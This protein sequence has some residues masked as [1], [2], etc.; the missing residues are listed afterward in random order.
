MRTR[1]IPGER[2][3]RVLLIIPCFNEEKRI[4]LSSF[5]NQIDGVDLNYLFV[6]DG[7]ADNT[8]ALI[9]DFCEDRDYAQTFHLVANV[10]KANAIF[11]AFQNSG[12]NHSQYD[13]IGY[14]DADLATPLSEIPRMMNFLDFYKGKEVAGIFGSRISRLGS[15]IKRQM[16]RH[17]LGRIFVTIVSNVLGVKCYDSQ[18]GA[19]LFTPAA[20][21][22]AFQESFIS[23][24]IFDVEILLRLKE[25]HIIEFPLFSWEDIPGSKVKV[26]REIFRVG[27]DLLRIRQKYLS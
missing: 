14:W 12:L 9:N 19:K 7:S 24:W 6:N 21:R 10:G 2:M 27:S 26:F 4:H 16:H 13:W 3:S 23:R 25:E 1:F 17:Y 20:A 11:H 22:I 15:Q 5:V 8:A 18:C